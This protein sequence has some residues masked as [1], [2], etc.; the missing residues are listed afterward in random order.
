MN[1]LIEGKAKLTYTKA[2]HKLKRTYCFGAV[3]FFAL[4]RYPLTTHVYRLYANN[5]RQL[6][7]KRFFIDP[8]QLLRVIDLF[9]F[10]SWGGKACVSSAHI[11]FD[12]HIR[13][14]I[15][16]AEHGLDFFK[17]GHLV[18]AYYALI[19]EADKP[20]LSSQH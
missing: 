18:P 1:W 17:R 20:I 5:I 9:F 19:A 3:P 2:H 7:R 10:T 14:T 4:F 12:A 11:A 16:V 15:N 13:P 8:G 6:S